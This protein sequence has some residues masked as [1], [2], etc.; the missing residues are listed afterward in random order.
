MSTVNFDTIHRIDWNCL[1]PR[2]A[3]VIPYVRNGGAYNFALGIDMQTGELTDF[4][5]CVEYIHEKHALNGALREFNE[6]SH[7]VF[8]DRFVN[9]LGDCRI[10]YSEGMAIVFI[11]VDVDMDDLSSRFLV[12]RDQSAEVEISSIVWLNML[13]FYQL[14]SN[15]EVALHGQNYRGYKLLVD[16]LQGLYET[17]SN[18]V[19]HL[20]GPSLLGPSFSGHPGLA[21]PVH[22]GPSTV[23]PGHLKQ[24]G[25][26]E[27]MSGDG[28]E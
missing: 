20:T 3:G 28:A 13:E 11:E 17:D 8:N 2:R 16:M 25:A 1:K 4:G 26:D 9:N 5:G 18:F 27:I 22:E 21:G 7:G 15:G 23:A 24:I 6:E 10:A 19:N 12:A 14:F